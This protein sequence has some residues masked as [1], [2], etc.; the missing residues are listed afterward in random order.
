VNRSQLRV[1]VGVV[2]LVSLA[3]PAWSQEPASIDLN[4]QVDGFERAAHAPFVGVPTDWSSSHL[5]FSTPPPGSEAEERVQQDPRYWLQQIRRAQLQSDDSIEPDTGA[6]RGKKTKPKKNKKLKIKNDWTVSLGGTGATVGPNFYPAKFTF[7]TTTASCSDYVALNTSLAGASAVAATGTGTFANTTSFATETVTINGQT[8]TATGVGIDT[9]S[10]EPASGATTVVDGVTYTW[11][12]TSCGAF[13][14]TAT[15]GCV[16]RSSNGVS[17]NVTNLQEAITNTCGGT[18]NCKVFGANPGASAVVSGSTVLV[19]NTTV[20]TN[21]GWSLTGINAQTLT[22]TGTISFAS[23]SSSTFALNSGTTVSTTTGATNLTTAINDDTASDGVTATSAAGVVTVTANT[24][25][26]AGNSIATT[27]TLAGFSWGGTTLAGGANGQAS[28]LALTNLYATTCGSTVP[29]TGWAYNTGG[30]ISTSVVLSLNGEQLAF[31][32]SSASGASLEVFRPVSGQGTSA[33]VPA[34]PGTSTTTAATYVTCKSGSGS[35]LLSLAF[36]NAANDTN[37][38]PYYVYSGTNADTLFVG[39]D[40]GYVHKFTG[41]F[42][43]TPAEVTTGGFPAEA[44]VV[45]ISSPIY[46]DPSGTAF[47]VS[48]YDGMSPGNGG[49]LHEVNAAT[50]ITMD[51]GNSNIL[52]PWTSGEAGCNSPGSSGDTTALTTDSPIVDSA[53][54]TDGAV[55]VFIGNNGAGN[56]AVYQFAPGFG[57]TTCGTMETV[58]TGSTTGV[59]LYSGTFDNIYFT[60][61]HSDDPSGNLYV[62][63]NTGGDAQLYRVPIASNAIGSP[64][65]I[66][67]TLSTATTTCSPVTEF[68]NGAVDQAYMSVQAS[69]RPANCGGTGCVMSFTITTALA[70]SATPSAVLPEA[71]GTSGIIVD[72][73]AGTTGASQIYFSTLTS[74]LVVQAAQSGL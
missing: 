10:G 34:T 74:A 16:V 43:G 62:C 21:I 65:A 22:P 53:A 2:L 41:V 35:C 23:T 14:P 24:A 25:G 26:T 71:G 13:T 58:G 60:S 40:T 42:N 5:I 17:F 55:Y 47:V 48:S 50:G 46:N 63:G 49:R 66:T 27:E 73:S 64:V 45:K 9:F 30:T 59:P 52:G 37:S 18:V 44:A 28:I 29:T 70:A 11:T 3:L 7:G 1:L 39:D 56:A 33:L 15:S 61:A 54:G 72:N 31:I 68:L 32:H 8:F 20:S 69:G 36:A 38:S 51:E 4:A 19:I 12:T 57:E 67:T 6:F